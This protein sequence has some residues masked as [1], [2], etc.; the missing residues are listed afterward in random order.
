VALATLVQ[1][2]AAFLASLA[3][4]DRAQVV[5]EQR[6][7]KPERRH[8]KVARET[9]A[10]FLRIEA[11]VAEIIRVLNEHTRIFERLPEAIRERTGFK[12]QP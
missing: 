7:L 10:R 6:H 5:A 1:T 9:E 8:L 2:Q 12:G 4:T 11:Q 3:E